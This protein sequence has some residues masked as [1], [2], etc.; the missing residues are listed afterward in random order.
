MDR[1]LKT[2][3]VSLAKRQEKPVHS[4]CAASERFFFHLPSADIFYELFQN[5]ISQ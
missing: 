5:K 2:A 4:G 1:L 3:A